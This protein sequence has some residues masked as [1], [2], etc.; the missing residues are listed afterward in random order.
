MGQLGFDT[1][2]LGAVRNLPPAPTG[3]GNRGT[4]PLRPGCIR[5]Y[6]KISPLPSGNYFTNQKTEDSKGKAPKL[7]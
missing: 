6:G 1:P 3:A 4:F 7:F 2:V 5:H